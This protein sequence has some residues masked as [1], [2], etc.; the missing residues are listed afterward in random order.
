MVCTVQQPA[1]LDQDK[2]GAAR[3]RHGLRTMVQVSGV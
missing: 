3:F 1:A 2:E